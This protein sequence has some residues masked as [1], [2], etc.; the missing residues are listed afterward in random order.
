MTGV[1]DAALHRLVRSDLRHHL[2]ADL[3]PGRTPV[4]EVVLHHPLGERLA[5]D[6]YQVRDAARLVQV[7]PD[8]G[9]DHWRDP[10]DHA[11]WESN[12]ASHPFR[13]FR[14]PAVRE[15]QHRLAGGVAVPA[16]IVAG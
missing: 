13:N 1:E 4:G 8:L 11:V 5:I 9:R 3:L 2:D 6:R 16:E 15:S 7:A 12:V 14:I 10:V